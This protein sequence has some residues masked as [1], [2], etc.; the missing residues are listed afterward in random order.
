MDINRLSLGDKIAGASAIAL[1]LIMFIF[2]WFGVE[3]ESDLIDLGGFAGAST[4]FNAWGSFSFIDIILL[5]TIIAALAMAYLHASRTRIDLP[6]SISVIVAALGVLSVLL[7]LF[8]IISPP[9][10]LDTGG[11]S[12]EGGEIN[13]TRKIG[14]FLG[15]IAA[16]ALA[17]GGYRAMQE[18]GTSFQE[19]GDQLR[20]RGG[21][22]TGSGTGSGPGTG[23]STGTSTG[24]GTGTGT[25]TPPPPPAGG[26]APPPPPPPPSSNV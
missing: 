5:I 9:D 20:D 25:V 16:A 26:T 23:S 4:S 24:A 19:A 8:R 13:N 15:L 17:Y 2:K 18:E 14:A 3:V 6:V 1:L 12:F 21:P 11:V 7:I 10:I 22:G